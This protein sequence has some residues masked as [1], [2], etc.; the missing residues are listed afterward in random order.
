MKT[1]GDFKSRGWIAVVGDVI[2]GGGG[3]ES[4]QLTERDVNNINFGGHIKEREVKLLV[5]RTDVEVRPAF[6]GLIDWE[7][8]DGEVFTGVEMAD[9]CWALNIVKWRPHFPSADK[10]ESTCEVNATSA[11]F[12]FAGWLTS[13][14]KPITFSSNHWATPA[15]D[16]IAEFIRVNKLNEECNFDRI[17]I[18]NDFKFPEQKSPYDVDAHVSGSDASIRYA[19]DKPVFTQAMAD[20][21][22]IPPIGSYAEIAEPTE[23]LSIRYEA[24]CKV[25]VYAIFTD[26]RGVKL[27]AF[28]DDGGKVGGVAVAECF[29]PIQTERERTTDKAAILIASKEVLHNQYPRALAIAEILYDA[30]LLK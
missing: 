1:I 9:L 5:W 19:D 3:K 29:K 28:V 14:E 24:G 26:D 12:A 2:K 25:K 15:A 30:G 23:Y 10:H 6:R 11:L 18:P 22:D 21:N 16:M 27:A 20:N 4:H 8:D 13:M 17:T 7:R